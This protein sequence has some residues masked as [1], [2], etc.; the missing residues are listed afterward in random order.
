MIYFFLQVAAHPRGM[1]G[2]ELKQKQTTEEG[3]LQTLAS[4]WADA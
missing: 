4:S 3:C 1:S 2:Q